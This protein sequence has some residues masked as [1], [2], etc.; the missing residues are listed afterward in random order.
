MQGRQAAAWNR[1]SCVSSRPGWCCCGLAPL[2]RSAD[3]RIRG[4]GGGGAGRR[5]HGP[6][7][8]ASHYAPRQPVRLNV[9][10]PEPDAFWI[11]FGAWPGE[12]SLSE[13]GD[14]V[15]AASRL[16]EALHRA[17][18]SDRPVIA[19]APIPNTGLGI[20]INDRLRRAA[21]AR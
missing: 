12:I 9:T 21:A 17:Q 3:D 4:A 7:Q 5:R 18:A 11:G 15:E 2:P 13:R 10:Q 19:V 20:A 1:P 16:F 8:L 14:L 6:G